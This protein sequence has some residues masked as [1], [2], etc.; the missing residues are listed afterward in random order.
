MGRRIKKN[1]PSATWEGGYKKTSQVQLGKE[2]IKKL[3]ST[4]WEGGYKKP[5]QV[6]LGKEFNS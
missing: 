2:D 1:F 4:T 3:Q 6:Q 5:S